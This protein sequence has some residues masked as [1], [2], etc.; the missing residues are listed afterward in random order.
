MHPAERLTAAEQRGVDVSAARY[1]LDR[2]ELDRAAGEITVGLL[3]DISAG[4]STLVQALLPDA[5]VISDVRGGTTQRSQRYRWTAPSGDALTLVDIPGTGAAADDAAL[6]E[7]QRC[8]MLLYVCEGDLTRSQFAAPESFSRAGETQRRGGEQD[9]SLQRRAAGLDR[10]PPAGT[11]AR[12]CCRAARA[13]G[14]C[15]RGRRP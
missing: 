1:E 9:R 4:K 8:H 5:H 10:R 7:A 11:L 13:G 14:G 12:R 3:G 15:Y 6:D 2:L